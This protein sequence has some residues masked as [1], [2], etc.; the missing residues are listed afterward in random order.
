M[1]VKYEAIE[2]QTE[3]RFSLVGSWS[4]ISAYEG[5]CNSEFDTKRVE[6]KHYS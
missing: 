1:N 6:D 4:N 3:Q 5:K 2:Q